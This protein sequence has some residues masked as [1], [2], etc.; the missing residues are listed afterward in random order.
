MKRECAAEPPEPS[1][2]LLLLE[3][4]WRNRRRW[5]RRRQRRLRNDSLD[6]GRRATA[7]RKKRIGGAQRAVL[8][9]DHEGLVRA[10]AKRRAAL[11]HKRH[12]SGQ[13][14]DAHGVGWDVDRI[15]I[16]RLDR[17]AGGEIGDA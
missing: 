11:R 3:Q 2:A 12:A 5:N 7:T 17:M 14:L 6:P 16:S 8:D 9:F 13:H 1:V 15:D 10:S 4:R